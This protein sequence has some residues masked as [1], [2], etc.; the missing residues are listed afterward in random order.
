[1]FEWVLNTP[2]PHYVVGFPKR[3]VYVFLAFK[4]RFSLVLSRYAVLK[5]I[6]L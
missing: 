4:L 6:E 1:M 2:L 5:H 3:V